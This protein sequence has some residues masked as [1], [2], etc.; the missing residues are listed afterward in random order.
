MLD[1][2]I[3]GHG[4]L[5]N[6]DRWRCDAAA[7]FEIIADRLDVLKHLVEIS[8]NGNLFHGISDLAV[9][10]PQPRGAASRFFMAPC[11]FVMGPPARHPSPRAL[12]RI[13]R[14]STRATGSR[15]DA[16]RGGLFGGLWQQPRGQSDGLPQS[17]VGP[18]S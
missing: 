7:Q 11:R 1:F 3:P 16:A 9:F 6:L 13:R 14:C 17:A 12:G 5:G 10:D 8:G 15:V 2:S 4:H 18:M